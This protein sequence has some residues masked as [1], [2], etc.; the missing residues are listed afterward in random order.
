MGV[1]NERYRPARRGV[2]EVVQI[3]REREQDHRRDDDAHDIGFGRR[4]RV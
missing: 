2:R 3:E 1:M 4:R